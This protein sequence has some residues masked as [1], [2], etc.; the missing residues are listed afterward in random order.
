MKKVSSKVWCRWGASCSGTPTPSTGCRRNIKMCGLLFLVAGRKCL[1]WVDLNLS[2]SER[3][4]EGREFFKI[5]RLFPNFFLTTL[6]KKKNQSHF[7]S[8]SVFYWF[9][10]QV[11]KGTFRIF[12]VSLVQPFTQV[13]RSLPKLDLPSLRIKTTNFY[14]RLK[15]VFFFSKTWANILPK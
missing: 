14:E 10:N 2:F 4:Q 5:N 13:I 6:K 3:K 7:I 1:K 15:Y 9:V 11:V 12:D 8:F